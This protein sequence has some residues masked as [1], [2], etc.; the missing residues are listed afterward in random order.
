MTIQLHKGVLS[1]NFSGKPRVLGTVENKVLSTNRNRAEHY[2]RKYDGY[3]FNFE[4]VNDVRFF[5]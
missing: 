2:M 5:D 3:G 4:V 1:V